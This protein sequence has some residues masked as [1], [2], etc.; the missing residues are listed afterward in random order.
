[1][2][3]PR[4]GRKQPPACQ[5]HRPVRSTLHAVRRCPPG[6]QALSVG[7]GGTSP[8]S[9]LACRERP[10][11]PAFCV[12][13]CIGAGLLMCKPQYNTH[14]YTVFPGNTAEER[15][16]VKVS[17]RPPLLSQHQGLLH[18]VTAQAV[19]W[20]VVG[21]GCKPA[22]PPHHRPPLESLLLWPPPPPLLLPSPL[23]CCCRL[24][25]RVRCRS[26]VACVLQGHHNETGVL[27]CVRHNS[28]YE[29]DVRR[30]SPFWDLQ[31]LKGACP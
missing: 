7:S 27:V 5:Q 6:L 21:S 8:G 14:V 12:Q 26:A 15:Y 31:N 23:R 19:S 10:S 17:L 1:M 28:K 24:S 11:A 18:A 22:A 20:Q 16:Y 4:V 13:S 3:Q 9:R 30:G 29:A 2:G 25:R